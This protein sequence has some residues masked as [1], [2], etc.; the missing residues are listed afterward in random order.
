MIS[1]TRVVITMAAIAPVGGV[2]VFP[3]ERPDGGSEGHT[4]GRIDARPRR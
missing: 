1:I 3:G 4:Y 2:L